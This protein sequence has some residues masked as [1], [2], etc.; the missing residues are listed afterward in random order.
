MQAIKEWALALIVISVVGTVILILAPS[1]TLEKSVKTAVAIVMLFMFVKPFFGGYK[2]NEL[3]INS[4]IIYES[5]SYDGNDY[6]ISGLRDE[7]DK[8][9]ILLLKNEGIS[10]VDIETVIKMN[11]EDELTVESVK[12][13]IP[14]QYS[15]NQERICNVI[16]NELGIVAEV[17]VVD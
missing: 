10:N 9:I 4:D 15:G 1:G 5:T 2:L 6:I 3:K 8:R 17:V 11:S 16:K 12:L 13:Y 7:I 14:K